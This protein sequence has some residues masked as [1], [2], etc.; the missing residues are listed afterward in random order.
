MSRN[1]S[2]LNK[3]PAD[4]ETS[5]AEMRETPLFLMSTTG[6]T[7]FVVKTDNPQAKPFKVYVGDNQRCTCGGGE[8]RGK[9]C[10]HLMFVMMKVLRVKATDPLAWQLSLVDSEVTQVL[11]RGKKPGNVAASETGDGPSPGTA[12]HAFLRRGQGAAASGRAGSEQEAAG[13]CVEGRDTRTRQDL[14]ADEVCPICQDD[15]TE[16]QM[17]SGHLCFCEHQCG[18]NLH[19]K[20]LRMY[21][22][23]LK[24]EKKPVL[25]PMCRA[26]WGEL[27]DEPKK[28]GHSTNMP[29]VKW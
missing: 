24:S 11:A 29:A 19:A 21:A 16:Q 28:V 20:C 7:V 10:V 8:A 23:H 22:T 26:E 5:V 12:R 9:L 2:Y 18:S 4:W 6:P 3:P 15:M 25:C 13:A 27:P 1:H 14:T 17:T